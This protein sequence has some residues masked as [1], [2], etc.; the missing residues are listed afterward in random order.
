[1]TVHNPELSTVA[2]ELERVLG[3][4]L[5]GGHRNIHFECRSL[6][7]IDSSGF[8]NVLGLNSNVPCPTFQPAGQ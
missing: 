2:P 7:F 3:E 6:A 5:D 8:G 4:L 1:M